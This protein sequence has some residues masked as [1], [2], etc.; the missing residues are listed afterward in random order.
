[1]VVRGTKNF[2][3]LI[4]DA[5]MEASDYEYTSPNDKGGDIIKGKAHSGMQ[6]SGKYLVDRHQKLLS[7]LLKLS[8][9]QK[10]EVTLI[11]HSL[12]A[13]AASIA[14]MEWNS[15]DSFE[16]QGGSGDVDV[17]AHVIGFGCPAVLSKELSM[18]T[19]QYITTVVAD[20]D[21]IPRMSGATLV[22]LLLDVTS[23]DYQKQAQ[24]DVEQALRAAKSRLALGLDE[25]DIQT[26]MGYVSSGLEKIANP[27]APPSTDRT[28]TSEERVEGTATAKEEDN[29]T[30]QE[31]QLPI[32][33]FPPGEC[34]H[35]Y[36][37]GSGISGSYVPC[38][39]FDEIDI[40]R[41]CVD[42]HLISSGY[43]RIFL[44]LMRDFTKDDHFSFD[45]RKE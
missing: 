38:T 8:K 24:R 7:T 27:M 20:A 26:V 42:D 11:G 4:T 17:S 13:G 45:K 22:N 43:R 31:Q 12:G 3:D 39:F 35:F 6:L 44:S 28:T 32:V 18:A 5:M 9:K 41:T 1:M 29:D 30:V 23:F 14:A 16:E 34:I 15:R 37:D 2:S 25:D 40:A 10:L 36:R 33:L 19:K 21:F